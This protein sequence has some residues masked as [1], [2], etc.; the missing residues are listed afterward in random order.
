MMTKIKNILLNLSYG[1]AI[2]L[3]VPFCILIFLIC[4]LLLPIFI[5]LG[6]F[7]DLL[8]RPLD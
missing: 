7:A 2:I 3:I 6:F 8:A 4:L 1:I 5:T